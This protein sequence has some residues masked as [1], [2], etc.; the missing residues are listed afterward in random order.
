MT[1]IGK[2]KWAAA[3]SVTVCCNGGDDDV[4]DPWDSRVQEC[5]ARDLGIDLSVW[6]GNTASMGR[7]AVHAFLHLSTWAHSI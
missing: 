2:F 3:K 1:S 6:S 7:H 5:R 4:A